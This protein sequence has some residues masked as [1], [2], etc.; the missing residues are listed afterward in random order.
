MSEYLC[1]PKIR[2]SRNLRHLS[3]PF[4]SCGMP[5]RARGMAAT[6]RS[7]DATTLQL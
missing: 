5:R 4:P 1:L 6:V 7:D 2:L 3:S